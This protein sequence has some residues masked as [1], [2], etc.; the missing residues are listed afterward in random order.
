M[1]S[2]PRDGAGLES[3]GADRG[4]H[5]HLDG[6]LDG[7]LD[8]G[9]RQVER[10]ARRATQWH[11]CSARNRAAWHAAL[12]RACEGPGCPASRRFCRDCIHGVSTLLPPRL[13]D[14]DG[15]G[16]RSADPSPVVRHL[17]PAG[18]HAYG[19]ACHAR[20]RGRGPW[21]CLRRETGLRPA[22]HSLL[23]RRDTSGPGREEEASFSLRAWVRDL[24]LFP[25][26][27]DGLPV[28]VL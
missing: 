11:P 25:L 27:P 10:G 4:I 7:D 18:T 12:A 19:K 9:P 8:R 23:G 21:L 15:D 13:L 22:C 20:R 14:L 1:E 16:D 5:E 17:P 28:N 3:W 6:H 2:V 24:P 26:A